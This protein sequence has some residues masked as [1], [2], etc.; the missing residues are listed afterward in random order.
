MHAHDRRYAVRIAQ[1]ARARFAR[2]EGH[3]VHLLAGN[4]CG[5]LAGQVNSSRIIQTYAG[6]DF[7]FQ[8][9]ISPT[10]SIKTS[11]HQVLNRY[12]MYRFRRKSASARQ[13]RGVI[14]VYGSFTV[15]RFS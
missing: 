8:A 14:D 7:T 13:Y 6:T 4:G 15:T 2:F 10:V 1:R 5:A 12:R 9:S 3:A 11:L